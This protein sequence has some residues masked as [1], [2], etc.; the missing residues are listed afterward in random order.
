M[1]NFWTSLDFE[2]DVTWSKNRVISEISR[3]PEVEG[4]NPADEILTA[5]ARFQLNNSKL[6]V[7]VV[8]LSINDNIKC[9]EN[10][11]QGLKWK[12]SW[13]R[14]KSGIT[15]KTKN[16]NLDYL[17]DPTFRNINRL[18]LFSFENGN[19]YPTRNSFD[20]YYMLFVE[21]KDLNVLIDNNP[22]FNQPLKNKQE[23]YEKLIEM[24]RNNDYTTGNLLHY[25]CH[26]KCYKRIG[27]DLSRQK[28]ASI[29]QQ[30]NF[31]G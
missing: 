2:V 7:L 8:T 15:T 1:S 30:I 16:N 13:N 22:F 6:H 9:L 21:I 10:I 23:V 25:F 11:K 26:E 5:E 3:T 19:D 28:I 14:W 29:P 4:V 24:S 18:F 27:I 12:I 31:V 20:E 17:I